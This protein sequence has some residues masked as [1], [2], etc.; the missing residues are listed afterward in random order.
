MKIRVTQD[1]IDNG[2]IVCNRCPV[3][4]AVQRNLGC[5]EVRVSYRL[6]QWVFSDGRRGLQKQPFS[7][8]RFV[9]KF[10]NSKE[11][12]PFNFILKGL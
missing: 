9:S 6:I 11:A 12:K 4:K 3:A 7:V 5:H 2:E 10:D 1:D 8:K